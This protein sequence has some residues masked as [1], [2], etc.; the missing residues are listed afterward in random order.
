LSTGIIKIMKQLKS[1]PPSGRQHRTEWADKLPD[2]KFRVFIDDA[3][4]VAGGAVQ[5]A[6]I[7]GITRSA[8]YQW[9]PPYRFDPYMP[10]SSARRLLKENP[11]FKAELKKLQ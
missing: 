8:I 1:K 6:R 5:L 2:V 11:E 9:R 4:K 3:I 10:V 7:L